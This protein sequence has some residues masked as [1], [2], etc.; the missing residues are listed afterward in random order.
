MATVCIDWIHPTTT[1]THITRSFVCYAVCDTFC[2]HAALREC[3]SVK[4]E[5]HLT[6]L[7]FG[8][9]VLARRLTCLLIFFVCLLQ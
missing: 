5:L 2:R 6:F 7:E 4:D 1:S 9:V 3:F 8:A